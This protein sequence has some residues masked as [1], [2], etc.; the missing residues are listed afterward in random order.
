MK[1]TPLRR[2]GRI[3]P[4]SKRRRKRDASYPAAREYVYA[5]SRGACE[6][7]AH[8]EACTGM[9]E[10]VH[11]VRGRVGRDPHDTDWLLGLSRACHEA[12][13]REPVWAVR[14]G[15]S[16]TRHGGAA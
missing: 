12:A 6:A 15:L 8:V 14:V 3:S 2:T 4:V 13:H 5:R 9:C 11:H 10:Q 1:R 16:V 7:P